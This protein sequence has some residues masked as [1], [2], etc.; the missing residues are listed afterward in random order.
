LLSCVDQLCFPPDSISTHPN[1]TDPD[2]GPS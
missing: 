2:C 1:P